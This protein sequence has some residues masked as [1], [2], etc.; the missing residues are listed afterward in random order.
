MIDITKVKYDLV[1]ITPAGAKI[2]LHEAQRG[3][4]WEEQPGELAVRLQAELLNIKT[5]V[6]WLHELLA[7]GGL[8]VLNA[9][10]GQGWKEVFRGSIFDWQY[11][12]AQR[13]IEIMAYDNLIYLNKSKDDRFYEAGTTAKTILMDV[14]ASWSIPLGQIDGPDIVL[15]KQVFRNQSVGGIINDVL[16]KVRL[17]G[18]GWWIVRSKVGKMDII[19]AG[20]NNTVYHF[21]SDSSVVDVLDHMEINDLVTQV[22]IIGQEDDKARDKVI[23]VV[24]GRTEFGLLREIL[25][26][27]EASKPSEATKA[28]KALLAERGKPMRS[29]RVEAPDL[30]FLRRGDKV[31]IVAATLN[32]YYLVQGVTHN[33]DRKSMTMEVTVPIE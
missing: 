9:E 13:R 10:W 15:S 3:L 11:S 21:G 6:G 24:D 5:D 30:P 19:Q 17:K 25:H 28:A 1:A 18:N 27:E 32:G 23:A 16:D 29:A 8:V 22:K 20:T 31:H 33:A 12:G 2:H 4:S 26:W 14:A 7:L